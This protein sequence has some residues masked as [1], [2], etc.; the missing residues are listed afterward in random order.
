MVP[1]GWFGKFRL[2]R[3]KFRAL[4]VDHEPQESIFEFSKSPVTPHYP[5]P[6][7]VVS[8]QITPYYRPF[9]KRKKAKKYLTFLKNTII[10]CLKSRKSTR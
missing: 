7:K 8:P 3:I 10:I 4:G 6:M 1:E 2:L 5:P 9:S